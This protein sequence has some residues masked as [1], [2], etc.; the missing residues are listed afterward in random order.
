MI[1]RLAFKHSRIIKKRERKW[2]EIE[3]FIQSG[4][5]TLGLSEANSNKYKY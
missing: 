3:F 4:K 1:K 2:H 5:T